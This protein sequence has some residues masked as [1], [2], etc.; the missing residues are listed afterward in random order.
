M[1]TDEAAKTL[2]DSFTFASPPGRWLGLDVGDPGPGPGGCTLSSL[3]APISVWPFSRVPPVCWQ[4][5]S[6]VTSLFFARGPSWSPGH[7]PDQAGGRLPGGGPKDGRSV[8]TALLCSW[9]SSPGGPRA[10]VEAPPGPELLGSRSARWFVP[11]RACVLS[12][13]PH[14]RDQIVRGSVSSKLLILFSDALV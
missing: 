9:H 1:N 11:G 10:S 5:L 3:A 6:S 14:P 8:G 12:P 7:W 4:A 13:P 2:L